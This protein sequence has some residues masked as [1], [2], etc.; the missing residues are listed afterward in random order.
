[1]ILKAEKVLVVGA[2]G[3][4]GAALVKELLNQG[5]KVLATDVSLADLSD[6]M[7]DLDVTADEA[8]L[9]LQQVDITDKHAVIEFFE[10]L[11]QIT[12]AVNCTYPRNSNYGNHFFDVTL[13][14]FNENL[15]MNL[16]S[17]FF[18]MQ[19]CAAYF[20]RKTTRLSLVNVSSVYGI[21]APKFE[22]YN[23]SE[24]TMP[25]EYAAIKSGLVHLSKYVTKYVGDSRFRINLVSPGGIFDH[26]PT[27]FLDAYRRETFGKGML[28][29]GEVLGS[30]V[31]L[32]SDNAQYVNGQDI[33]VDDGFIL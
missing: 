2:A 10:S 14:D 31:Y 18:F 17:S 21:I 3:L 23:G 32:L 1:M 26:Q 33:V 28:D 7:R 25:V 29:V 22:I 6:R 4:L 8:V 15:S 11:D 20:L 13:D 27:A 30:I 19:Q 12:G 9:Q 24:M 16:G 5:A